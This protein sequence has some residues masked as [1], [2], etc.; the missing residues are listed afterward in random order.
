[1]AKINASHW[2][3]ITSV[4]VTRVHFF[5]VAAYMA[6]IIIFDSWNLITHDAVAQ[7]W[8]WAGALLA[9]N[10]VIWYAAR[11]KFKNNS[12][13]VG[14]VLILIMADIVFAGMNVFWERG[15]ASKA[16]GLFI[17]PIITAAVLRSRTTLLATATLSAAGYSIAAVRYFYI[18]YGESFKVELYGTVGFYCALFFI[19]AF[20]LLIVISPRE[21]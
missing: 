12:I 18:H 1:M 13:Y 5:F 15:I 19:T 17:V 10:A 8:T 7:R 20:L 4:R 11:M 16:V 2:L 6:A 3:Q 14:L 9:L 21:E